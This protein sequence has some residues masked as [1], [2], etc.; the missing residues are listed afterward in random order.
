MTRIR[1]L[2]RSNVR[3]QQHARARSRQ[4]APRACQRLNGKRHRRPRTGSRF[5]SS[6]RRPNAPLTQRGRPRPGRRAAPADHRSPPAELV[7]RFSPR[8]TSRKPVRSNH[9]PGGAALD[10]RAEGTT[11]GDDLRFH[12]VRP[13]PGPRG[14]YLHPRD[15][16]NASAPQITKRLPRPAAGN[17]SRRLIRP[18]AWNPNFSYC[19]SRR[20]R[21]TLLGLAT[22]CHAA[23]RSRAGPSRTSGKGRKCEADLKQPTCA[24][25]A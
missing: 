18:R 15:L 22:V 13:A 12:L 23:P 16:A 3:T 17:D 7:R 9:E 21:G 2:C 6:V 19:A 5:R 8:S 4:C 10:G 1:S 14:E 20:S 24:G 11:L 25:P